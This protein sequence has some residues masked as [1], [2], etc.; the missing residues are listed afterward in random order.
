MFN[1]R[2]HQTH[3]EPERITSLLQDLE[4]IVC[5]YTNNILDKDEPLMRSGSGCI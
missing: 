4:D 2:M 5:C 3:P 1:K